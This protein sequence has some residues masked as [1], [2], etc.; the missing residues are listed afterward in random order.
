MDQKRDIHGHVVYGD[1]EAKDGLNYLDY[2]LKGDAAEAFFRQAKQTG[3]AVF[4]DEHERRF[5]LTYKGGAYY[6]ERT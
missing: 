3:L 5:S 2:D 6:M 1:N 4:E